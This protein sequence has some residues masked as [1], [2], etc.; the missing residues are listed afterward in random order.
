MRS[1]IGAVFL[2][3]L[4][5]VGLLF[6][7]DHDPSAAAA[8]RTP[9]APAPSPTIAQGPAEG[10]PSVAP[11]SSAPPASAAG[12]AQVDAAGT[13]LLPAATSSPRAGKQSARFKTAAATAT[14]FM[15]A[16]A[17]PAP[18][19]DQSA[20]WAKVEV[21]MSPLAAADYQDTDPAA[22]P[23]DRVTGRA[24]V[25]PTDAPSDLL[26]AVKVP[27]DAG[28]YIVELQTTETGMQVTR[29]VPP[30]AGTAPQ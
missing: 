28:D 29:A 11:T 12:D 3:A 5:A 20:W 8:P 16:F 17:R 18:P 30:S 10:T 23:F 15:R 6:L 7:H 14:A 25:M 13:P 22:V 27:T 9:S 21:F 26:T 19:L 1:L 4:I 24:A 2:V